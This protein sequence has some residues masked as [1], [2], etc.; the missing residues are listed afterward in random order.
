VHVHPQGGEKKIRAK[1][2][3]KV[4][5]A[6]S[7]CEISSVLKATTGNKTTCVTTHF[8]EINNRK[9]RVYYLSYCLK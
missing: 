4:V 9:Q 2:T 1:F 5:S 6:H 8:K 7:H 3:G